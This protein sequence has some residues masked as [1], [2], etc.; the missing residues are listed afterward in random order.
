MSR[1]IGW[2]EGTRA[3][4][5]R[6]MPERLGH[7]L[8]RRRRARGTGSRRR[9]WRRPGSR[10]R[11]PPPGSAR[12]ASSGRRS[13][14][15]CRRPRPRAGGSVTPPGTSTPGRCSTPARASIMAG[16][17]LSQVATPSTPLRRGQRADQAAEDDRRVVAVGQAVHHP[18]RPLG[19]AVA[20]VGDHPGERRHARALAAP[21]PPPAPAGRS[22][23]A[24]CD[25]PARSACRPGRA[26][27]P[28][29]SGSGTGRGRTSRGVPAHP[30]VLAQAEQVA[31]GPVAEHLVG[32]GERS[33]GPS[34]FVCTSRTAPSAESTMSA[35]EID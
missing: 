29:C 32:Q 10:A 30:G 21:R 25:T 11:R 6:A 23:S 34:A 20:R 9:G 19:P 35:N 2:P 8:R 31:R 22:P 27:P 17:P 26:G 12:R 3:A 7:D 5:G 18:G 15:S 24:P 14:G 4:C 33:A 28:G 1:Q 13:T 16:R